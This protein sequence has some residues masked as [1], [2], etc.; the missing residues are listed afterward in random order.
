[1]GFSI[2]QDQWLLG[3]GVLFLLSSCAVLAV[4]KRQRD[5]VL[6]RLQFSRRR[7]SGAS[8]PPRSFSPS[9]R[10][11]I[12][13]SGNP[14]YRTTYPQSRRE[15]LP[16]LAKMLP[17]ANAKILVQSEPSVDCILQNQL[18]MTESYAVE[19]DEPRYTPTGFS[20]TEIKAM[21]DF[22]A[23]DVLTGTPL[24]QAYENFDPAKALPRPYRPFRWAYHQTMCK[25]FL[26]HQYSQLFTNWPSFCQNG[27]G[28]VARG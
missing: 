24:P 9:K 12:A 25:L 17:S 8:T 1:M 6:E 27:I 5:A 28:M 15:V 7:A 21:G 14:D 10:A 16:D 22:P 20:T 4:N 3:L 23:Y 13:T 19:S 26:H 11:S 2:F 18:P